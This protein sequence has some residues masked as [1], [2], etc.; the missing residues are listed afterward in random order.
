MSKLQ[1]TVVVLALL[2]STVWGIAVIANSFFVTRGGSV[3]FHFNQLPFIYSCFSFVGV[4]V[5]TREFFLY[6]SS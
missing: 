1:E 6:Y 2:T 5:F 4:L 3:L